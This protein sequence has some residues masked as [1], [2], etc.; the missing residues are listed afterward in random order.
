[1]KAKSVTSGWSQLQQTFLA[2]FEARM[3]WTASCSELLV[4]KK[5]AEKNAN[6]FFWIGLSFLLIGC[7]GAMCSILGALSSSTFGSNFETLY[8]GVFIII[9]FCG[10]YLL[11]KSI[12]LVDGQ[13]AEQLLMWN[14][15]ETMFSE[16]CDYKQIK[17][18]ISSSQLVAHLE[19]EVRQT[20]REILH[21][22]KFDT[23]PMK[24]SSGKL[25]SYLK[26]LMALVVRLELMGT[27]QISI[28]MCGDEESLYDARAD[29]FYTVLF[30][31]PDFVIP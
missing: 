31:N 30:R 24:D 7:G 19:N 14:D 13:V 29:W 4:Q 26:N 21:I 2:L 5:T 8:C 9:L 18:D 3:V 1:M 15:C 20:V 12:T 23:N 16:I 10:M 28:G 11:D 27:G 25:K 6:R 17:D 22:Q